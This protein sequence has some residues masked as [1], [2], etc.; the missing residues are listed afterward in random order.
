L[1]R[2]LLVLAV[3]AVAGVMVAAMIEHGSFLGPL[4]IFGGE[5]SSD[6]SVST[7]QGVGRSV[8]VAAVV[9]AGLTP[10]YW[11]QLVLLSCATLLLTSLGSRAHLFTSVVLVVI[12]LGI[13][14]IRARRRAALLFFL[15]VAAAGVYAGWAVFLET[16]AGEILD[17]ASSTSWGM[18]LE[19][20]SLAIS[21]IRAH[22]VL[23][24]FGYHLREV[25]PGGYAH[26]A[27]SAWTQFGFLGFLL[28]AGL[29][30]YFTVLSTRRV[31]STGGSSA[32][33]R[34]AWL[35]NTSSMILGLSAEP[36]FSAL[37]GL[38]WGFT[39]NALLEERRRQ[40]KVRYAA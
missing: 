8:L 9:S 29:I 22:P 27:L 3:A 36:V 39:L 13:S 6:Q 38:G 1:R 32:A 15:L 33:W 12:V 21:V 5:V 18:R 26:N 40:T 14:M 20:Q 37:P 34:I 31:M 28:Y 23:G 25:G 2:A 7:Y 11:R 10:I 17:L 35:A 4:F 19:V 30:T 16:R 24:D